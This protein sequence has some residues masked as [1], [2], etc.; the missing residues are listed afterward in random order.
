MDCPNEFEEARARRIA[1]NNRRMQ[2]LGIP[3]LKD[4]LRT[5]A[6]HASQLSTQ[7]RS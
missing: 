6:K 7:A 5:E 1:Q 2:E 4:Q 3:E